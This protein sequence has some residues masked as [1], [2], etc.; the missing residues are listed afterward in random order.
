VTT[1][2]RASD[3]TRAT[4]TRE[5]VEAAQGVID[6]YVE[7]MQLP[8]SK[9]WSDQHMPYLRGLITQAI[10]DAHALGHQQGLERGRRMVGM[11]LHDFLEDEG[12]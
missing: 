5:D 3:P 11:R 4:I 9:G 8:V 6:A 12:L 2:E 1:P 7:H 10:T